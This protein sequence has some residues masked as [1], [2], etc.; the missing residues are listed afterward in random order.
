MNY[1]GTRFPNFINDHEITFLR[2]LLTSYFLRLLTFTSYSS[3]YS[4]LTLPIYLFWSVLS[5]PILSYAILCYLMLSYAILCYPMRSYAILCY[6]I[7]CYLM[8][9]YAILSYPM[10]SYAILSY[11]LLSYPNLSYPIL[12]YAILS[13]PVLFS[14]S[15]DTTAPCERIDCWLAACPW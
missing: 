11:T 12:S 7:L 15:H 4:L 13:C 1:L 8:L 14:L 5:Y 9:S 2:R 3:R 6:P 10:L